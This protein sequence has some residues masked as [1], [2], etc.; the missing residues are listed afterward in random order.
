MNI[1]SLPLNEI[2]EKISGL[3]E[4]E[5]MK[6][7]IENNPWHDHQSVY[8]HTMLVVENLEKYSNNKLLIVATL[9]HDV[10]KPETLG[11]D[12]KTGYTTS[13]NHEK[14]GSRKIKNIGK[15]IGLTEK[16]I[17]YL[18]KIIA[19]HGETHEMVNNI[20]RNESDDPYAEE[21]FRTYGDLS[22]DLFLLALADT[23][24]GTLGASDP[25]GLRKRKEVLER[26]MRRKK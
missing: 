9:L 5:A 23:I 22:R 26:L 15:R 14:I 16:E 13:V 2:Q 3:P 20:I 4:I 1:T 21:F 19:Y 11:V 17:Q 18:E 10:A 24:G 6:N 8:E 7:A 25:E 12:L